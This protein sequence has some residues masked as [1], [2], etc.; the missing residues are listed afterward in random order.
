MT[1]FVSMTF[2]D[3]RDSPVADVTRLAP[4]FVP[5]IGDRIKMDAGDDPWPKVTKRYFD[6]TTPASPTA[7]LDVR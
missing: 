1:D 6:Y 4:T 7:R 5:E 2:H 3:L